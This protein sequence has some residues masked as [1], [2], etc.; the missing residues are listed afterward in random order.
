MKTIRRGE[1]EE[2]EAS[3]DTTTSTSTAIAADRSCIA[4]KP[5]PHPAAA[6][7]AA[8]ATTTGTMD[9][10]DVEDDV[11]EEAVEA[12][13]ES[14]TV[15]EQNR[16][17]EGE[18]EAVSRTEYFTAVTIDRRVHHRLRCPDRRRDHRPVGLPC[19]FKPIRESAFA[20]AQYSLPRS[21][22]TMISV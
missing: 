1:E 5:G 14:V 21:T 8:S 3:R 10:N 15:I 4:P 16:D 18:K 13:D 20:P 12:A 19:I 7:V 11:D 6:A 2:E 22:W 9:E 17:G